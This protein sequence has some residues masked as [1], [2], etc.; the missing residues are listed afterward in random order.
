[1]INFFRKIRHKLL[2]ENKVSKYLLYAVGEIMLVVVGILI[3]L[4]INNWNEVEKSK[5]LEIEILKEIK[6]SLENDLEDLLFNLNYESVKL[7][8]QNV[9]I[10]WIEKDLT[11]NDSL[12]THFANNTYV[13]YFNDNTGAY[14]TLK[15]IGIR[16][17]NNDS[18]RRQISELYDIDYQEY[19]MYNIEHSKSN[20]QLNAFNSKYYNRLDFSLNKMELIDPKGLRADKEYLYHLKTMRSW[21]EILTSEFIPNVIN[22]INKTIKMI[23]DELQNRG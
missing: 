15:Q 5:N 20:D 23:E 14:H 6:S 16:I 18:L 17:I 8:S 3:A 10:D 19:N 22:A 12:S 7:A 11:Y 2:S 21:N 1:M 13:T 4:Q 9:I